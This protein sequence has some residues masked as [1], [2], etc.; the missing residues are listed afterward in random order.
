MTN[1]C[2]GF[3]CPAPQGLAVPKMANALSTVKEVA[4]NPKQLFRTS[5]PEARSLTYAAGLRDASAPAAAPS[6]AASDADAMEA[7][8]LRIERLRADGGIPDSSYGDVG[9]SGGYGAQ[10]EAKKAPKKLSDIA[11]NP[12]I[13]ATFGNLGTFAIGKPPS[14]PPRPTAAAP[15]PA[16]PQPS[17]PLP[18]NIGSSI[19]G[20]LLPPVVPAAPAAA[21]MPAPAPMPAAG[22]SSA[23]AFDPEFD[24]FGDASAGGGGT[25][26]AE[27]FDPF[28]SL[29]GETHGAG[30]AAVGAEAAAPKAKGQDPFADLL[31]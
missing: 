3:F 2:A 17:L 20:S 26:Q 10:E 6:A 24:P 27:E 16:L 9:G 19:R 11:V 22:P 23:A 8:R 28:A 30:H 25:P 18:T 12:K 29:A 1:P 7:T 31:A 21:A 5:D 4:H 13:A 15:A 14:A